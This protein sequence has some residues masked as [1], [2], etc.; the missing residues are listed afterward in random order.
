MTILKRRKTR[1]VATRVPVGN[2]QDHKQ[3]LE[4]TT[5]Q[6]E[7][8][9]DN[10]YATWELTETSSRST[11]SSKR[12]TPAS[13]QTEALVLRQKEDMYVRR[14]HDC[15]VHCDCPSECRHALYEAL[16]RAETN[17]TSSSGSDDVPQLSNEDDDTESLSG[18]PTPPEH[19]ELE[20]SSASLQA[21]S[22]DDLDGGFF[23]AATATEPDY[24]GDDEFDLGT[25]IAKS[26]CAV[27]HP[28]ADVERPTEVKTQ[29]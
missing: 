10:A 7:K 21:V 3:E 2:A 28:V 14:E 11:K 29:R 17:A 27:E 5:A 26:A 16:Q 18:P 6:K 1:E 4:A 15:S 12:W 25:Y 20:H 9:A 13:P 24:D 23:F 19:Q 8:A 22:S